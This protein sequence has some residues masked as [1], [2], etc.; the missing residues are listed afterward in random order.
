LIKVEFATV[1]A[2][3]KKPCWDVWVCQGRMCKA[4]GSDAIDE[5]LASAVAERPDDDQARLRLL[6]GGC[7]GL[8]EMAANV[9]ARR[10]ASPGRR[11][12]PGVDRLT[13][14]GKANETIYSKM[15]PDDALRALAE[16]LDEDGPL[17]ELT[18]RARETDI[19]ADSKTARNIRRLRSKWTKS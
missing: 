4:H 1:L 9:V 5:A 6:R 19:P 3:V 11:P 18:L 15:T 12:D 2:K 14:T 8:C 13:I 17:V 10:W 7:Y 16:H